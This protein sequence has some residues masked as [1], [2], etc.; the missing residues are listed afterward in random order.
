M[1]N[2][3]IQQN[4][5][6]LVSAAMVVSL[7]CVSAF[8][9][10]VHL[11]DGSLVRGAITSVKDGVLVVKTDFAGEIRIPLDKIAGVSTDAEQTITLKGG[12]TYT[13]RLHYVDGK[14]QVLQKDAAEPLEIPSLGEVVPLPPPGAPPV[15]ANW[16]GRAELMLN[17]SSGNSDRINASAGVSAMRAGII[18]RLTLYLRGQYEESNG[19]RSK[20][21]VL[22]GV[23]YERDLSPRLF[24]Y[25]RLELEYDE[26]ENLD[27]RST[28]GGGLG[29][30][31]IRN[32][33]QDFKM[34]GGLAYQHEEFGDGSSDDKPLAEAGYDYR[35]DI[36]QWLR[37]NS[38]L[39]YFVD[40]T[41]VDD[42]RA[43]AENAA[44]LPITP[45]Q[46]WKLR[47]G[48]RNEIDSD[49]LPDID[50]LDTTYYM[51]LVYNWN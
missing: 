37:F 25:T 28:V 42:W 43:T 49:P 34:R 6:F 50:S 31:L 46:G 30:F 11:L 23:R 33:R 16:T 15:P 41:D 36:R 47:L 32:P 29:Y 51:G 24:A 1:I 3:I 17:G 10:E 45:T 39:T 18:D 2:R 48:F 21:E 14:Q 5:K 26:F 40:P 8:A 20:N 27:L 19:D 12:G 22:G 4:A 7:A 9:D 38:T 13:G 44:E 35:L